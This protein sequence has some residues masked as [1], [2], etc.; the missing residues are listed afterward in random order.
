VET[1]FGKATSGARRLIELIIVSCVIHSIA[2]LCGREA[3]TSNRPDL[4]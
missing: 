1:S 3:A 4:T 2:R